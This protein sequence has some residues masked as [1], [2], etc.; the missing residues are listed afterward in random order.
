ML[1]FV[2]LLFAH[3]VGDFILQPRSWVEQKE[4]SR[5]SAPQLYFHCAVHGVLSALVLWDSWSWLLGIAI[6]T[7]HFVI[8]LAK[9]SLQTPH[10]KSK[11]FIAD[12]VAHFISLAVLG[13]IWIG[14][15]FEIGY[16]FQMPELWIYSAAVLLVT[17]VARIGMSVLLSNWTM[18]L[19]ESKDASLA[20]AG[21]YIGILER[22]LVFV[23]IV[24]G[25]WEAVG[26]LLAAKSVFRFGDLT[27]A[28]DRKLTEYILIGTLLSFTVAIVTGLTV[29]KLISLC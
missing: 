19:P 7:V 2:K 21:K 13:N 26:F 5:I 1:I 10:S 23:F 20:N 14:K 17:V 12:Q 3:F 8:D 11:W 4:Q 6:A 27:Q 15:G 16:L 18:V 25:R 22:L 28:K 9:I 29:V 24:Y